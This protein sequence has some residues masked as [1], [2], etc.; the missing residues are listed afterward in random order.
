MT[1]EE[2]IVKIR[3]IFDDTAK[4]KK[5]FF[6]LAILTVISCAVDVLLPK[7][8]IIFNL[9]RTV[10]AFANAIPLFLSCYYVACR[11]H[12]AYVKK[13]EE[14][15]EL[16]YDYRLRYTAATRLKQG[17]IFCAVLA[18]IAMM[19]SFSPIYTVA[20][21][22]V[23]AGIFATVLYCRMTEKERFYKENDMPD[24][25]DIAMEK[26]END[27]KLTREAL[28]SLRKEEIKRKREKGQDAT[29]EEKLLGY[30]PMDEDGNDLFS[31]PEDDEDDES[32]EDID[33][34]EDEDDYED[35]DKKQASQRRASMRH[36]NGL[37]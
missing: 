10:L 13:A 23:M 12:D 4:M 11:Q 22:S 33:D 27:R 30:S 29:E 7:H 25:R 14:N 16:Y 28:I 21:S 17:I 3:S 2:L 8:S 36:R 6:A 31:K 18:A 19:T 20:A 34:L 15:D 24:P 26:I 35:D 5:I 37:F 9:I 32:D 1:L